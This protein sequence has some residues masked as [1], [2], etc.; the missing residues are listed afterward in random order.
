MYDIDEDILGNVCILGC[1]KAN[2]DTTEAEVST[3]KQH[4]YNT[5]NPDKVAIT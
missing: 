4:I 3:P 2:I 1:K 5:T